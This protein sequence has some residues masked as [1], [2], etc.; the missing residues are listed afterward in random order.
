MIVP[1]SAAIWSSLGRPATLD[2]PTFNIDKIKD[3]ILD[4]R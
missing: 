4:V 1:K 3:I 2:E